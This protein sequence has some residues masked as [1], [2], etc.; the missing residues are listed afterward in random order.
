MSPARTA[1]ALLTAS[2]ALV[3]IAARS[4]ADV[5]VTL[6]QFRALVVLA[7]RSGLTVTEL[8]GS[9]SIHPSTATRLCDR[10]VARSLV[11]RSPSA[12]DRRE[13][14]VQLTA[15]GG[16]LVARVSDRRRADLEAIASAM[17][18]ADRAAVVEAL[19][20]FAAAAGEPELLD[21]FGWVSG[22][23]DPP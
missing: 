11:R 15:T 8:A 7:G 1:G 5:D 19:E 12:E 17:G 9:L 18:P 2:R 22:T 14:I 10:L 21:P 3:G 6:P 23:D 20:I 13:T 4:L 16:R